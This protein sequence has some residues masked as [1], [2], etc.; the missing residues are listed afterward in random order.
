[1]QNGFMFCGLM[2]QNGKESDFVMTQ[3]KS[4]ILKFLAGYGV[5]FVV[6][7]CYYTW[8]ILSPY[9][10]EFAPH[11]TP[12]QLALP[13]TINIAVSAFGGLS[14]PFLIRRFS[15][16]GAIRFSGIVL[17][18]GWLIMLLLQWCPHIS[19]LCVGYAALGYGNGVIYPVI[20]QVLTACCPNRSGTVSGSLLLVIGVGALVVGTMEQALISTVGLFGFCAIF[21]ILYFVLH[22]FGGCWIVMPGGWTSL[23]HRSGIGE[24]TLIK[25]AART[26]VFWTFFFWLALLAS[27][28]LLVI[29]NVGMIFTYYQAPA[30]VSMLVMLVTGI[31]C[32]LMGLAIDRFGLRGAMVGASAFSLF[33][34]VSLLVGHWS[35]ATWLILVGT[36]FSGGAYGTTTASKM[37][38]VLR[39]YGSDHMTTFFGV[40]NM[41]IIPASFLGPYISGQLMMLGE[42]YYPCFLFITALSAVSLLLVILGGSSFKNRTNKLCES[43][44]E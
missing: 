9:F 6:N 30:S 4:P 21:A 1:M 26:P 42:G 28:G 2:S 37:A 39:L 12:A 7:G 33:A 20:A 23:H 24:S 31:G 32:Q 25:C 19:V 43:D 10:A 3:M 22:W 13:A 16:R 5:L 18:A 11:W 14:A 27:A 35:E 44:R 15:H 29:N 8:S 38:G 40:F 36:L 41:N 17:A 34:S